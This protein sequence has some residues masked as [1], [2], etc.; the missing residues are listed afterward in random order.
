MAITPDEVRKYLDNPLAMAVLET[1]EDQVQE[2]TWY[3]RYANTV[4][5]GAG[6]VATAGA[7][8]L[9]SGLDLPAWASVTITV[10]VAVAGVFAVKQT[11]NGL[12]PSVVDRIA[13]PIL[14]QRTVERV[15]QALEPAIG[16]HAARTAL[17]DPEPETGLFQ[18]PTSHPRISD[19][20]DQ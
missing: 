4:N 19:Y 9:T 12:T 16:R 7:G 6:L 18:A 2:Q 3:Q 14:I 1:L 13:N 11:K 8:L 15:A 10:L 5:A 17:Q 20:P